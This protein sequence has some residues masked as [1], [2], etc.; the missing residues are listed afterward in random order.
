MFEREIKFIYDFNLNKVKKIGSFLTYDQLISADLHPAILKYIS[1]EID[2]LIFEDRQKMLR[3]SVFDYS[4]EKIN[5]YFALISKEVKGTKRFSLDYIKKLILHATSFNI[6]F[7]VRPN[8]SLLKFIYDEEE[9][10]TTLEIKQIL[11]YVYYYDY[12]NDVLIS[13]LNKKKLLSLNNSE[14]KQLLVKIDKI[15]IDSY[16]NDM[17]ET[18][19]NSIAEFLNIGN[20]NKSKVPIKAVE[21]FL[22]EKGLIE[23]VDILKKSTEGEE[24]YKYEVSDLLAI[25]KKVKLHREDDTEEFEEEKIPQLATESIEVKEEI[26]GEEIIEPEYELEPEEKFELEENKIEEEIIVEETIPV[27]EPV[28]EDLPVNEEPEPID[29]IDQL[30]PEEPEPVDEIEQLQHEEPEHAEDINIIKEEDQAD[31][32]TDEKI[33][34]EEST[35]ELEAATDV[36][37]E[38]LVYEG[39]E[40]VISNDMDIFKEEFGEDFEKGTEPAEILESNQDDIQ[41]AE[42]N[43]P[44]II[45]NVEGEVTEETEP[46]LSSETEEDIFTDIQGE[47]EI[48]FNSSDEETISEEDDVVSFKM[49]S[50]TLSEDETPFEEEGII[51]EKVFDN[52]AEERIEDKLDEIVI[53]FNSENESKHEPVKDEEDFTEDININEHFENIIT[54]EDEML[55]TDSSET[56]TDIAESFVEH[57]E[58]VNEPELKTEESDDIAG[59]AELENNNEIKVDDKESNASQSSGFVQPSFFDEKIE[60]EEDADEYEEIQVDDE[61][62]DYEFSIEE[63]AEVTAPEEVENKTEEVFEQPEEKTAEEELKIEEKENDLKADE[64][65]DIIKSGKVDLSNI[66]ENKYMKKIVEKLFDNDMEEFADLVEKLTECSSVNEAHYNL[67]EYMKENGIEATSKEAIKFFDIISEYFEN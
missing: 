64:G 67:N 21:G 47:E 10:K 55:N 33:T 8:W 17:L 37:Q 12:L 11:N 50:E 25:L 4:S 9:H 42:S 28:L 3:D 16:L 51:E 49:D 60:L 56:D 32:V 48:I 31:L 19:L 5:H 38:V 66:M 39:L 36:R 27:P 6:N 61:L 30:Q 44:E 35:E 62:E 14:F 18:S 58:E 23:H 26:V 22:K 59:E 29:E 20:T 24:K 7:L 65:N 1:A 13:Y 52:N 15:G 2:Y 40:E 57:K 45:E 54:I 63:E 41:T 46:E 34:E 43:Q 53:E